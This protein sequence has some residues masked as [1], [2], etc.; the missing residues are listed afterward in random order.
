[1]LW[2]SIILEIFLDNIVYKANVSAKKNHNIDKAYI[3][4][5]SLNR[6]FRY[7]NYLQSLRN[8]IAL[9]KYYWDLKEVRLTPV[10]NWKIIKRSSS[11][12]SLHGKCNLCLEEKICKLK[13]FNKNLLNP[14]KQMIAACRHRTKFLVWFNFIYF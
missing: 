10:I 11:T 8:Q 5:T 3:G 12:N 9:S 14:Q 4:M 2:L 1:M 13:L 7:D 6:K